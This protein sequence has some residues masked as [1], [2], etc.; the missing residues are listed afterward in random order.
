[1]C[2]CDLDGNG[3]PELAY[4]YSWGSGL[5]RSILGILAFD[6]GVPKP[7]PSKFV[8]K[9]VTLKLSKTDDRDVSVTASDV[10]FG[11]LSVL[12]TKE[13]NKL[14]VALDKGLSKEMRKLIWK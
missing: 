11:T 1:M 5:H 13:G 4:T 8:V 6:S 3:V 12:A 7:W 9:S 14:D 2:V 10:L